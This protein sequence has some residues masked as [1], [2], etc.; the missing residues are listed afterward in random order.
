M[1]PKSLSDC[2]LVLAPL[3]LVNTLAVE[4]GLGDFFL[5]VR[6]TCQ[7][8]TRLAVAYV[9][10]LGRSRQSFPSRASFSPAGGGQDLIR[11]EVDEISFDGEV[12]TVRWKREI[13]QGNLEASYQRLREL[14]S[15]DLEEAATPHFERSQ[16]LTI[17]SSGGV[18]EMNVVVFRA[19]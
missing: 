13:A 9:S 12:H 17:P 14:S 16:A 5:S 18:V 19:V 6:G 3:L 2:D 10:D 15:A 8:G 1:Q 11:S 4:D 7:S